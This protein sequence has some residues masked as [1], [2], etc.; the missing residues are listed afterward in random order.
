MDSALEVYL[1]R[2]IVNMPLEE[3]WELPDDDITLIFDDGSIDT[4]MRETW[5]SRYGWEIHRVYPE[6]PLLMEH[7]VHGIRVT[8]T[9]HLNLMGKA[10]FACFNRYRELGCPVNK[11]E[12][13]RLIY[14]A[15][16]QLYNDTIIKLPE[17]VGT[18][19]VL[20]FIEVAEQ[21]EIVNANQ[22]LRDKPFVSSMDI[23]DSYKVI[24]KTIMTKSTLSD[25]NLVNGLR[26]KVVK[27]DQILQCVG[28]RGFVA[29]ADGYIYPR[30]II[31]GYLGGHMRIADSLKDSRS[32]VTAMYN[33]KDPMRQSETFNRMLQF[34]SA[35]IP[36]LHQH[37]DHNLIDKLSGLLSSVGAYDYKSMVED[38]GSTDYIPFAIRDSKTLNNTLGI[39]FWNE[40]TKQLDTI[41]QG[42]TEL[43]GRILQL[44][45]APSC[46]IADRGGFCITC[47]GDVGLGVPLGTNIGHASC[48]TMQEKATQ[49][50]LSTK[51]HMQSMVADKFAIRPGD[52]SFI[53]SD[54]KNTIFVAERLKG[55]KYS[56]YI[57]EA[58][59]Q[60]LHDLLYIDAKDI[61]PLSP[62]RVSELA[63]VQFA[64]HNDDESVNLADVEVAITSRLSS[65]SK[66]M[67]LYIKHVG[68]TI[69]ELGNYI[70]DMKH[71]DVK[72]PF[73]VL[74]LKQFSMI[75][76]VLTI[77]KCFQ[78]GTATRGAPTLRSYPNMAEAINGLYDLVSLKL[79]VNLSHL[80]V[81]ALTLAVENVE[82]RD[83]R[84]PMDKM[85][86]KIVSYKEAIKYRSFS[87]I[88][89]YQHQF[90]TLFSPSAP[91]VP[92][93]PAHPLDPLLFG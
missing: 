60:G 3:V 36:R 4:S 92:N 90:E 25:N 89:A 22:S 91:L 10:A 74:P 32:A 72:Q 76:Y 21:E 39:R 28:A 64:V 63:Y 69:G 45:L 85:N 59:A 93:R 17:Y 15:F 44:R 73:L 19:S 78:G 56:I 75:D 47:M 37:Y 2:D 9:T 77:K 57:P 7:H 34:T 66:E 40:D 53:S 50:L 88:L 82:V 31:S 11:E 62:S 68:W 46:K 33:Q 41:T 43:I 26:S 30:A 65:L 42:R 35:Y 83:Y 86:G 18:V 6:T 13:S 12:V 48:T 27:M 52:R 79:E 84:P 8:P 14:Q 58:A 24:E 16:N 87:A 1:A 54:G 20:D 70:I 38:C 55:K 67:L 80:A 71:W 49:G 61:E 29:D 81:I 5:Y 23:D 51:H